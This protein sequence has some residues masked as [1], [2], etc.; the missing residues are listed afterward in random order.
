MDRKPVLSVVLGGLLLS[1]CTSATQ[2]PG[3]STARPTPRRPPA[4]AQT[5]PRHLPLASRL[6]GAEATRRAASWKERLS[7][8][9][10]EERR[11][12]ESVNAR[13]FGNLA[14]TSE[15]EQRWQLAS[16]YPTPEEWLAARQMA[17]PELHVLALSR[18]PKGMLFY[19]DRELGRL[20]QARQR[21]AETGSPQGDLDPAIMQP[22]VEAESFATQA[23]HVTGSPFAAY[24]VASVYRGTR[25]EREAMAAAILVAGALGDPR[26]R[27]LAEKI[28]AEGPIDFPLLMTMQTMMWNALHRQRR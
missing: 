22:Q 16:G 13:Y 25:Y 19:V 11:Y 26:A 9:S 12:L 28:Q 7:S 21:I 27:Q 15:E 4:A 23:L 5:D 10:Y 18:D 2:A 1:A 3:E 20:A 17:E 24:Q 8:L 6:P 14:F